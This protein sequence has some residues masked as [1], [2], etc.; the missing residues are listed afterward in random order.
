MKK[1]SERRKIGMV[2]A[3]AVLFAT[4]IFVSVGIAST[5]T[6]YVPDDYTKIQLAIDNAKAGDIIVVRDGW[7]F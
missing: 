2:L 1:E 3:F 7:Y 6:I 4:L 5:T